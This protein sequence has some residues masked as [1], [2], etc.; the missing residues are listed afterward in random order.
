VTGAAG[1]GRRALVTV[2]SVER[3]VVPWRW[4]RA[5]AF[6]VATVSLT[7]AMHRLAHGDAPS[8]PLLVLTTALVAFGVLP[9][10]RRE[11][12][13]GEIALTM[14]ALQGVLHVLFTRWPT[15][16]DATL[17]AALYQPGTAPIAGG[18]EQDAVMLFAH[19]AAACVLAWW[20]RCGEARLWALARA[21][22]RT[23]LLLFRATPSIR[24][25]P[26]APPR[27]RRLLGRRIGLL[28]L[29]ALG[30]SVV[31]RGPPGAVAVPA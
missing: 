25:S 14:T 12:R 17:H 29:R 20:L 2:D 10:I 27:S 31:R 23:V 13:F 26:A 28:R 1:P 5:G 22:G 18:F 8:L 6:A 3:G 4:P 19:G 16:H 7:A 11:R 15:A 21:A 30:C 24:V 9:V